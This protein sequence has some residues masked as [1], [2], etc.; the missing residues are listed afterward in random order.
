MRALDL[1][2]G[3]PG[4]LVAEGP[5][6]I[7]PAPNSSG[8]IATLFAVGSPFA[9]ATDVRLRARGLP[10]NEFGYFLASRTPGVPGAFGLHL[11]V[12][13][14][15][16]RFNAPAQIQFSGLEGGFELDVDLSSIPL[17][18]PVRAERGDTWHFQA[19]FRDTPSGAGSG[20]TDSIVIE[21]Q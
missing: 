11:C 8:S 1:A 13:L 10:V 5:D 7:P 16:G 20:F 21:F 12:G 17:S 3:A 2:Q 19:W 9:D 4:R 15:V 18:P 14:P 6:C